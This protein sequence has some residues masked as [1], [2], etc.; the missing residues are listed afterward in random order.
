M[1]E[2]S[3]KVVPSNP[4]IRNVCIY[5]CVKAQHISAY[6]VIVLSLHTQRMSSYTTRQS[7]QISLLPNHHQVKLLLYLRFRNL[8][9]AEP[10]DLL[11]LPPSPLEDNPDLG[12]L[13]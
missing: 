3:S 6:I 4:T 5:S 9:L 2:R 12:S 7:V 1:T 8:I 13:G 10:T 11:S